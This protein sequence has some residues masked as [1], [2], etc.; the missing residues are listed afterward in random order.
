MTHPHLTQS[1]A[2]LAWLA[3]LLMAIQPACASTL[4]RADFRVGTTVGVDAGNQGFNFAWD[5]SPLRQW[6]GG[7]RIG[8]PTF[9]TANVGGSLDARM[10]Y[11]ALDPKPGLPHVAIIFGT[12]I[13]SEQFSTMFTPTDIAPYAGICL[14]YSI[15]QPVTARLNLAPGFKNGPMWGGTSLEVAYRL[16]SNLEVTASLHS[17]SVSLGAR[18]EL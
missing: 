9:Q 14:A 11:H 18:M 7:V 8:L 4:A 15:L 16:Q 6:S 2:T 3:T 5:V 1:V 17:D 13:R 10:L 12:R